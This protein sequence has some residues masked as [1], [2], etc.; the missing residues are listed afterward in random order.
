MSRKRSRIE[1]F[2]VATPNRRRKQRQAEDLLK[3]NVCI[4]IVGFLYAHVGARAASLCVCEPRRCV[5][6][7]WF[8]R[9]THHCCLQ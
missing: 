4:P 3:P 2:G 1:F 9:A 5:G 7:S 8:S 6:V